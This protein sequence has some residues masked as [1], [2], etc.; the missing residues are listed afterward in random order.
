MCR[1]ADRGLHRDHAAWRLDAAVT[2]IFANHSVDRVE[3][4]DVHNGHRPAGTTWTEL[5]PEIAILARCRRR[6]VQ[7]A[8]IDRDSVPTP[9]RVETVPWS[10]PETRIKLWCGRVTRPISVAK[11]VM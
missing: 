10:V 4:G 7:T 8:G 1:L 3:H 11:A 2:L 6:M 5:L 9:D